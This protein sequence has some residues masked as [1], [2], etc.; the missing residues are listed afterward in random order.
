VAT[1]T[2]IAAG[3]H[4]VVVVLGAYADDLKQE[5]SGLPVSQV[6]NEDWATG[7]AGSLVTGLQATTELAPAVDALIFMVCDQPFVTTSLLHKLLTAR[8]ESGKPIVASKYAGISGTPALFG[9]EVFPALRELTGDAG[10]KRLIKQ[11]GDRVVSVDFPKGH[12]D[13]DTK[14]D[15][16]T[17]MQQE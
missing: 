2:A 17:F 7:M 15:Y 1:E 4:P 6:R 8:Q 3:M 13:I 12:I 9:K 16:D 10:A 14:N 11:F 5:L